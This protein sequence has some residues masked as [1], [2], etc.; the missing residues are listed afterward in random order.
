MAELGKKNG[1]IS[2]SIR[3]SLYNGRPFHLSYMD[4]E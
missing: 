2:A 1:V 4:L 3:H